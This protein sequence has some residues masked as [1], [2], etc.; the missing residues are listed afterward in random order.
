MSGRFTRVPGI[1]FATAVRENQEI[2]SLAAACDAWL[3]LQSHQAAA[4]NA[5]HSADRRFCRYLLRASDA[6][7][8]DTIPL[9][10][11]TIAQSLGM[12]RTTATLIAQDL[13]QRGMINYRRGR[14]MIADRP[15]LEIAACD[16]HAMLAK[17]NW[18]AEQTGQ[19]SSGHPLDRPDLSKAGTLSVEP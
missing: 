9:T 17:R 6:L 5:A 11:E 8:S 2:G 16:C 3:L 18:P 1:A 10:Q 7:A 4:C 14:I 12:R 13:Q 19:L 15:R